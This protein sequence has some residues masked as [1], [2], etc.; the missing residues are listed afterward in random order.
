MLSKASY[1][2]PVAFSVPALHAQMSVWSVALFMIIKFRIGPFPPDPDLIS[3]G[4]YSI[5]DR[6][7]RWREL[8]F[9][10]CHDFIYSLIDGVNSIFYGL[11]RLLLDHLWD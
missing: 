11:I 10:V 3:G 7:R 8:K 6:N 2:L 9:D 4:P 5:C 1:N